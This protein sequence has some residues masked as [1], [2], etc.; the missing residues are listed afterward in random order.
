[1]KQLHLVKFIAS[2]L[3]AI[4]VL[5]AQHLLKEN[6]MPPIVNTDICN[7]SL[8][9][10]ENYRYSLPQ[11]VLEGFLS[12]KAFDNQEEYTSE[13]L[14]RLR[15][16]INELYQSILATQSA[17]KN[18]AIITAGAPGA[19]KTVKLKQDL[20]IL[21]SKGRNYAYICPDDVCL[22]NQTSTYLADIANSEES[23][24][25]KQNAYNKW[26]PGS[27]AATHLI[28]GNLIREKCAFYFGSTSSGPATGKFFEFLRTQGYKI[29]LIHVSAPDDVRWGSIQERDKTFV[30]TTEQDVKEKGLL[31][32]Q[33]INDTFLKYADEIE[34]Y[35]RGGVTQDAVL[36]ARWLRNDDVLECAGTLEILEPDQYKQ[37]KSVH[38]AAIEILEKPELLWE[39]AVE[40]KSTILG[41][42]S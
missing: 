34:F 4:A 16:D 14:Q 15:S 31:L 21:A 11:K 3:P 42:Q 25:A 5:N 10:N 1:M 23:M 8:I 19:G 32:P 27:N 30:Q 39:E 38:N 26:R 22:R 2:I 37:I 35:Y 13:E 29:R 28:L 17:E 7:L 18:V 41:N 12:G 20:E 33:R 36:A 40:S 6:N 24:T 9:Y